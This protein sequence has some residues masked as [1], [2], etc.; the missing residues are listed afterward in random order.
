MGQTINPQ[1]LTRPITTRDLLLH[2]ARFASAGILVLS[3]HVF[4][5]DL[6]QSG[7]YNSAL[8]E[9][10]SMFTTEGTSVNQMGENNDV[11]VFQRGTGSE[12]QVF[13]TQ[14]T[15]TG[16]LNSATTTQ[17]ALQGS[18]VIQ[19]TGSQNQAHVE[20]Q[21][22]YDAAAEILQTGTNNSVDLRQLSFTEADQQALH[23]SITQD[24]NDN[25]VTATQ[26]AFYT[27]QLTVTQNGTGNILQLQQNRGES[28]DDR[29]S[30]VTVEMTGDANEVY[31]VHRGVFA[32]G[33]AD[34]H[35]SGSGNILDLEQ[36]WE[37]TKTHIYS[38]NSDNNRD[39]ILQQS[40]SWQEILIER[41]DTNNSRVDIVQN[42]W[43]FSAEV[44]QIASEGAIAEFDQFED[45]LG[46]DSEIEQIDV[47]DSLA[48]I[49]HRATGSGKI[50]QSGVDN[51]QALIQMYSGD[52]PELTIV[53][54]GGSGNHAEINLESGPHLTA[55]ID[56][57]GSFNDAR[58]SH[59]TSTLVGEQATY[60]KSITQ[61]GDHNTAVIA[62]NF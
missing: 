12:Q 36:A 53:Q 16:E 49:E 40:Y 7:M 6:Q 13:V 46:A 17:L 60:N 47:T 59:L 25:Q 56:Q 8:V 45:F 5:I 23:A 55:L 30:E 57:S 1:N 19:Q 44:R 50:I 41:E 24:G 3:T 2:T 52:N 10:E 42:G 58:I 43:A 29:D 14:I 31:I 26:H 38:I 62:Q 34:I 51:S 33:L 20:Q 32:G 54:T 22:V 39:S 37:T 35:Y 27:A 9:Q 4:A 21:E 48:R 61:I 11:T 18:I 28:L 15:Q